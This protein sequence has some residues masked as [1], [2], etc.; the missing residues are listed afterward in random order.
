MGVLVAGD[1]LGGGGYGGGAVG[2]GVRVAAV[3]EDDVG[4]QAVAVEAVDFADEVAGDGVG[5]GVFPV[6]GHG[7]PEDGNQA[8]A[9]GDA[10]H[11]GAARAEG[12]TKVADRRSR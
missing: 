3:V 6:G 11:L 12:R 5:G 8:E 10:Q 9:A 4:G 7:V 2:G 1:E